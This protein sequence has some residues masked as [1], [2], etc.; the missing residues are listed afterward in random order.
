MPDV[1]SMKK[2]DIISYIE[3][4]GCKMLKNKLTG[5]ETKKEIVEY[6]VRCGCPKIKKLLTQK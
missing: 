6:L 4:S 5:N 1:Y 3:K 2:D